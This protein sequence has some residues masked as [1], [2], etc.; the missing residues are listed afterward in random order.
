MNVSEDQLSRW[1]Q[2]P[3]ETEEGKCQETVRRVTNAVRRK[4]NT[5][6][7]IILQG[8]YKNRTNVR[9]DSD[10]DIAV[11]HDSYY[12]PDLGNLTEQEKIIY[13]ANHPNSTYTFAQF[14]T[15]IQIALEAEFN[16]GEVARKDKCLRVSKNDQRVNAD[17]VPCFEYKRFISPYT[18]GATGIAFKADSGPLVNSFPEQHYNNGVAKNDR[19]G[20]MYKSVVRILKNVRNELVDRRTINDKA[21]T[22]FFIECLTW[23]VSPDNLFSAST[24]TTAARNILV[25]IWNEMADSARADGYMEVNN[26]KRLFRDN[27][28]TPQQARAFMEQAWSFLG[29]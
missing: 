19:T 6:V 15:D 11:R 24:Y 12:F 7:T 10:V 14:K 8:S 25:T 17:V 22:S 2:A 5:S 26:L 21:M 27:N 3:S 23:N 13:H 4:F 9:R 28:R 20:R 1:A 16:Y 18:F 29:Y